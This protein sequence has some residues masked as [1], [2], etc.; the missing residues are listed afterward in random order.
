[1]PA[2]GGRLPEGKNIVEKIVR[3][4]WSEVYRKKERCPEFPA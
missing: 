3:I 4:N 2:G 1:L